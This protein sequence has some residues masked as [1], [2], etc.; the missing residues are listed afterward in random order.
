MYK[1]H[2]ELS[3]KPFSLI[4]DPDF[5]YLSRRHKL[6]LNLLEY[7]L[8]EQTGFVVITGEIGSGKTTLIHRTLRSVSDEMTIGLVSN[9]HPSLG[10]LLSWIVLSFGIDPKGMEKPEVY[11]AFIEFVINQYAAGK[12][13]VVIIDEAQNLS[14]E[15]L[16][17][18]RMLSN[19]NSGK[20][21]VL[22]LILSGQPELFDRLKKPH[23][24]QFV[25]RIGVNYHIDPLDL[26]ETRQYIAHRLKV[27]G[28]KR[29]IF[30]DLACA[31]V[32]LYTGGVPRLINILCDL[33][34]V[35]RYAEGRKNIDADTVIDVAL[36]RMKGGLTP[37]REGAH[38]LD[39]EQA[40]R[41]AAELLESNVA[42]LT[43]S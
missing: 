18:V 12:R 1:Q 34:M 38:A 23:L 16:E 8:R 4:P 24:R 19:T 28:A 26:S 27:A 13:T 14:E 25:Q 36:N 33:C 22:Q 9:T 21:Y 17:E 6:A 37:F 40:R 20:D 11:Q 31:A 32:Y 5:L 35:Y 10:E 3:E 41:S 39:R 29:R 43:S 42:A 30:N 2:F 7:G 15:A